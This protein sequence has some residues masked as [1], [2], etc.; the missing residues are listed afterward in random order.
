[1]LTRTAL[2]SSTAARASVAPRLTRTYAQ[3]GAAG[4]EP[5]NQERGNSKMPIYLAGAIAILVG[6]Y[7]TGV[8]NT[9]PTPAVKNMQHAMHGK[10]PE[11][12]AAAGTREDSQDEPV[13][14]GGDL[15]ARK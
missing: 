7:F 1:M 2:R 8:F 4:P 10:T 15:K 12:R 5:I 14:A 6:G 3:Q 11:A 13:T 9:P